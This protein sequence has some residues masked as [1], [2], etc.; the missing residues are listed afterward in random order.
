MWQRAKDDPAGFWGDMAANLHW[1]RKWDKVLE[2]RDAQYEVVRRWEDQRVVQLSRSAPDDLAEEQGRHH[3]GRRAGRFARPALP[4][5]ASGS[6]PL[7][8][9]SQKARHQDGRPRNALHADD[10]RTRHRHAGLRADRRDPLDHLRR[11]QR[12]RHRRPQQRCQVADW[13][14]RPTAAGAAA[15]RWP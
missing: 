1:F 5:S 4:G 2:R 7:R 12:R 15:K 10:P 13:S 9:R 6:L 8:Q 14:S 3:L 11:I